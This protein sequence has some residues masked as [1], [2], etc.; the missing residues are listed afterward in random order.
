MPFIG[1]VV[2]V[3][4]GI[5][6]ITQTADRAKSGR[7]MAMAGVVLGIISLL[8]PVV[9]LPALNAAREQ[10]NRVHC[11]QNLRQ[12]GHSLLAYADIHDDRFPE[13]LEDLMQ[14][15]A[16]PPAAAF[17]CPDDTKT[18]PS[19]ISPEATALD[20]ADGHHCSY[21]Y[22]GDGLKSDSPPDTVLLYEPLSI[23]HDKGMH[24]LYA[25][26]RVGWLSAENAQSILDQA[27]AG[28]RPVRVIPG[29][30]DASE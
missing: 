7:G 4:T 8:S 15:P 20:L 13:K 28:V 22:V 5:V 10:A 11:A 6:G 25:D 1:G 9:L 18:P 26:G 14:M 21:L 16:P 2:A 12:I 3:V 24:V 27:A 19:G 30:R 29:S 17:V 23:H